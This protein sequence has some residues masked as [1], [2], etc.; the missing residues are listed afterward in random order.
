[1]CFSPQRRAI[2]RLRNFKKCSETVSFLTF[3]LGNVLLATAACNFSTSQLQKVVRN[4]DV[5]YIFTCKCASRHSGVQFFNISTS[6]S[7]PKLRC[8]VPFHLK[9]CFSPQRRA[10]FQHLNFKKWSETVSFLAFWLQNV[11]LATAACNFWFLLSPHDS[12]PAALTSLLFDS[13]D[14]RIIG[15]TQRFATP[16]T[17]GADVSSFFWLLRNC[18]FFLLTLLHLLTLLSDF[19]SSH[20]LFICFST[21]HIV[22]SLLFKL[23]STTLYYKVLLL[24]YSVLQSTTPYCTVLLQYY[25]ILQSTTPVLRSTTQYYSSTTLYYKVL[26]QYYSVLQ[27]TTPLLRTTKYYSVLQSTTPV[28]LCTTQY[29]SNTTPVLHSTTPILL[30]TTQYYSSTTLYYKVLLQYYSVLHQYY[31]VLQST[32]LYYNRR[33]NKCH[34]PTSPNTVPATKNDSHDRSLSDMKR[35]LQCA[36]QQRL[37]SNVTKYCA[38]HEKWFPWLILL[39]YETSFTM[40]GATEVTIQRHQIL[41]LPRKMIPMTD[42][43]HIWNVI[44]NKRS[45]RG[46]HPTS[47]NTAPATK[48]DRPKSQ[49]ILLKTDET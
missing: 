22:G 39:T 34:C 26:L 14:T 45:N 15:K 17:F 46:Y 33:S 47:P 25:S 48:N 9:M 38:C 30:C 35:H 3:W 23:P 12:A 28:L 19:T 16:L 32:T 40:R 27:S 20:L 1:M 41:R 49:R 13:P 24:Y 43:C 44:Y 2:F 7:G 21:L 10:I 11:L 42:P 5:L 37:P 18:I 6:K 31:S 29:Y 4:W 36:E 8:F